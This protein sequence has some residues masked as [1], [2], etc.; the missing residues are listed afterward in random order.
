[1]EIINGIKRG[2]NIR[3]P[4]RG[5]LPNLVGESVLVMYLSGIEEPC[6]NR[7]VCTRVEMYNHYDELTIVS[8]SAKGFTV[9][10]GDVSLIQIT[11]YNTMFK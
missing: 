4:L 11:N 1:M 10:D 5:P 8:T 6:E 3:V 7:G 2:N 9:P